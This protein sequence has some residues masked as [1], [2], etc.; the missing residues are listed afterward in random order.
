MQFVL[1]FYDNPKL[2]AKRS[3]EKWQ[4]AT[5][6]WRCKFDVREDSA[7]SGIFTIIFYA[8]FSHN[9]STKYVQQIMKIIKKQNKIINSLLFIPG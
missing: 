7:L 8:A 2:Q 9:N 1:V 3:V 4:H 5:I 6:L